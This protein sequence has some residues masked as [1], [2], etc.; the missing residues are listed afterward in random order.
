MKNF[1]RTLGRLGAL[2]ALLLT[3]SMSSAIAKKVKFVVDMSGLVKSSFGIHITGDFQTLAGY[4][5]GDWNSTSTEMFQEPGDTNLYSLV[6]DIPAMTKYEYKFVNGV[7]FY[8]VEFVPIVSRVGYNFNDNRWIYIDSLDA[9]TM[10][11]APLMFSKNAPIG[12]RCARFLVDMQGLTVP[13]TGVHVAGSFQNWDPASMRMYSFGGSVYEYIGYEDTTVTA[14]EY[15]YINGNAWGVDESVPGAC[16][17]NNNRSTPLLVDTLLSAVCFAS[18]VAC[19]LVAIAQATAA[20]LTIYPNPAVDVATIRLNHLD[21]DWSLRILD[22]QGR[23][24]QQRSGAGAQSLRIAREGLQAGLYF[25][26]TVGADNSR[27]TQKL[28]FL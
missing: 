24:V 7:Q 16:A 13:N 8:E 10:V 2:T 23:V 9:D 19:P 4:P 1:L 5:G 6:V 11:L 17:T 3:L 18:C 12:Q 27:T 22:A 21:G 26:E 25:V 15:K 20:E 28:I 14:I